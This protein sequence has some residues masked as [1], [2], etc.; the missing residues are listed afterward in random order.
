MMNFDN[1]KHSAIA[2]IAAVVFT[3]TAV[4]AAV[5]PARIAETSPVQIAAQTADVADVSARG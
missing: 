4:G 5:G 3:A 2:A 1:L